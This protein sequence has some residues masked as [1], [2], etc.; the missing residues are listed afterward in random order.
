[1][2]ITHHREKLINSIVYFVT[3]TKYCGI[4]KLMKLL[5]F[6]DFWHFKLTG[7]PVTGSEYFAWAN[8]PVPREVHNELSGTMKSDMAASIKKT[9]F[10]DSSFI[11]FSPKRKFDQ[12][13][14]SERE[15]ELLEII[16][17]MFKDLK[18]E[19]IVE[20]SHLKNKPWAKTK[21]TRGLFHKIDYVLAVDEDED[22]ISMEQAIDTIEEISEVH[23]LFGV[24]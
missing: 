12:E 11:K 8:G 22:S 14:F 9:E 16:S 18:S 20:I 23:K 13:Y 3:H 21:E 15:L 10:S 19:E 17:F 6:L 24:A 2:I 4:T 1:M 5:Y 7:K